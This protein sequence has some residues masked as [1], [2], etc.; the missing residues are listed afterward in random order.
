M[1]YQPDPKATVYFT[2]P[3]TRCGDLKPWALDLT[4]QLARHWIPPQ[5]REV[6]SSHTD[7]LRHLPEQHHGRVN[8]RRRPP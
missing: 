2:W 7:A 5:P 3:A 8:G 6:T 4:R 1:T